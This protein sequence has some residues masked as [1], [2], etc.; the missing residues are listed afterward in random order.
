[1]AKKPSK[2]SKAP[3]PKK[4]ASPVKKKEASK[5]AASKRASTRKS[6]EKKVSTTKTT[7]S[8]KTTKTTTAPKA[9]STTKAP[10]V[11]SSK[12]TP[13]KEGAIMGVESLED[14]KETATEIYRFV[15]E[16][17]RDGSLIVATLVICVI[18][19]VVWQRG[20]E[21][22]WINNSR[23][24]VEKRL[25]SPLFGTLAMEKKLE[26]LGGLLQEHKGSQL[27]M[28]ILNKK[29]ELLYLQGKKKGE[30]DG[31]KNFQFV[32]ANLE[33]AYSLYEK[34]ANS[35]FAPTLKLVAKAN[36]ERIQKEID[37]LTTPPNFKK[38]G[39]YASTV[40]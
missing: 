9:A 24:K 33:E 25:A 34:I 10:K 39:V 12:E 28:V 17:H 27:E 26:E 38:M 13:P 31:K 2:D 30:K 1:M 7:K 16:K 20:A 4:K 6:K 37:L 40:N 32:K 3:K 14:A 22:R 18:A 35:P 5:K 36:M 23:I 29:A 8:T 19:F 11:V 21:H 15:W